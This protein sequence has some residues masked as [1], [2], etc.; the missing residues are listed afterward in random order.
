MKKD[1]E[2]LDRYGMD[3]MPMLP[4]ERK[5]TD[6]EWDSFFKKF[7]DTLAHSGDGI[8]DVRGLFSPDMART[9]SAGSA[10][11]STTTPTE[12]PVSPDATDAIN[13]RR[14]RSTVSAARFAA[15]GRQMFLGL[16][17]SAHAMAVTALRANDGLHAR[18]WQK[19]E[20]YYLQIAR[21]TPP[22]ITT[23]SV[24]ATNVAAFSHA[25]LRARQA[26]YP[27]VSSLFRNMGVFWYLIGSQI[28]ANRQ[29][30]QVLF[31]PELFRLDPDDIQKIQAQHRAAFAP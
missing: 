12:L 20:N 9:M 6:A 17:Q 21:Q 29:T 8:Q 28:Q 27:S 3:K 18:R 25:S 15:P 10:A 26:G 11:T 13:A 24:L 1:R 4:G 23:A 5:R 16:A 14:N 30:V 2:I 7:D 31:P 22:Q 19:W